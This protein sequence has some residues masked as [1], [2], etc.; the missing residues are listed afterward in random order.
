LLD[1][2]AISTSTSE[3]KTPLQQY[4]ER[5]KDGGHNGCNVSS[6]SIFMLNGCTACNGL[7]GAYINVGVWFS[8]AQYKIIAIELA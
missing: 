3:T 8:D 5:W 4:I 7:L 1:E 6:M 2:V